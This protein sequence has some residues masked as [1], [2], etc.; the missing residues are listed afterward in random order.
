MARSVCEGRGEIE[1]RRRRG[2]GVSTRS[3]INTAKP[4]GP[5]KNR[6]SGRERPHLTLEMPI[7]F[8]IEPR[9]PGPPPGILPPLLIARSAAINVK[10]TM[11]PT[12][13]G[14]VTSWAH[15]R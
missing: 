5:R 8:P 14:D 11:I 15:K 10:S 6:G 3:R 12:W 4:G 7:I 2:G 1:R 13:A 9:P